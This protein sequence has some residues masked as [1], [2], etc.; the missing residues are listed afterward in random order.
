MFDISQQQLD[1][2]ITLKLAEMLRTALGIIKR[3]VA[4]TILSQYPLT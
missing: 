2:F 3:F 1:Y 4:I